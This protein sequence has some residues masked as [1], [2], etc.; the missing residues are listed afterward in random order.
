[1]EE[2]S[3]SAAEPSALTLAAIAAAGLLIRQ[4]LRRFCAE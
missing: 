1:M 3:C 4:L 2:G